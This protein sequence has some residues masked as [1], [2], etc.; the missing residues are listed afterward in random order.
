[1]SEKEE[2]ILEIIGDA[3]ED[4]DDSQQN[5]IAGMAAGMAHGKREI[6]EEES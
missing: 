2:E 5:Y 6:V 3:F 1:M 4:L